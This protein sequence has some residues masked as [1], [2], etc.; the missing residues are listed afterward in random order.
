MDVLGLQPPPR[1][2]HLRHCW[3]HTLEALASFDLDHWLQSAESDV[4]HR[5][6]RVKGRERG[7]GVGINLFYASSR[8][9]RLPSSSLADTAASACPFFLLL[10]FRSNKLR[11]Q[12]HYCLYSKTRNSCHLWNGTQQKVLVED[13]RDINQP[14]KSLQPISAVPLSSQESYAC[15]RN[16]SLLFVNPCWPCLGSTFPWYAC[17]MSTVVYWSPYIS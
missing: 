4:R 1:K 9:R 17:H 5:G 12:C 7:K 10:W 15:E 11:E 14:K 13:T 2:S 6:G 3:Y 16:F 8:G